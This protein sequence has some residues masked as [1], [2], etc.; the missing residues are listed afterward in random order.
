MSYEIIPSGGI[1]INK[2]KVKINNKIEDRYLI[3]LKYDSNNVSPRIFRWSLNCVTET[4]EEAFAYFQSLFSRLVGGSIQPTDSKNLSDYEVYKNFASRRYKLIEKA[5]YTKEYDIYKNILKENDYVVSD[6]D[7]E[8]VKNYE[9]LDGVILNNIL[10]NRIQN[11]K[12][13]T[14]VLNQYELGLPYKEKTE[15]EKE[16][17]INGFLNEYKNN[18]YYP[19]NK[20]LDYIKEMDILIQQIIMDR[21]SS[22]SEKLIDRVLNKDNDKNRNFRSFKN[23]F[24]ENLFNV[25]YIKKKLQDDE[26]LLVNKNTVFKI[27]KYNMEEDSGFYFVEKINSFIREFPSQF[28]TLL[29]E[30]KEE[31][32]DLIEQKNQKTINKNPKKTKAELIESEDIFDVFLLND[33][34]I[35]NLEKIDEINKS[36]LN[37]NKDKKSEKVF[38]SLLDTLNYIDYYKIQQKYINKYLKDLYEKIEFRGN[39]LNI[40]EIRNNLNSYLKGKKIQEDGRF[41]ELFV[42][43]YSSTKEE[44]VLIKDIILKHKGKQINS[45]ISKEIYKEIIEYFIKK[46]NRPKEEMQINNYFNSY[47]KINKYEEFHSAIIN[48]IIKKLN[49]NKETVELLCDVFLIDFQEKYVK[50]ESVMKTTLLMEKEEAI[51]IKE[52]KRNQLAKKEKLTKEVK[53]K[54]GYEL[55][56]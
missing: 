28:S 7:F 51:K 46:N 54:V 34:F 23:I 43:Y 10:I 33:K 3:F 26:K 14:T 45:K 36:K 24:F 2:I 30:K 29:K 9:E 53:K 27:F 42:N 48:K 40:T 12:V 18:I 8:S 49:L 6:K 41:V 52:E 44:S 5:E 11:Q 21:T 17:I 55:S 1:Y 35:E 13:Q 47:F 37:E 25:G 50:K 4:K 20:N 39:D 22:F 38:K 32:I 56:I 15:E 31:I 16:I 19:T